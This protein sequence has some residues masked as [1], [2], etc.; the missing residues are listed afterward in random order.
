M[1][2]L[3]KLIYDLN[4]GSP[5]RFPDAI[6]WRLSPGRVALEQ[7][8]HIPQFRILADSA[9][10]KSKLVVTPYRTAEAAADESKRLFNLRLCGART[11]CTEN[12]YGKYLNNNILT[13]AQPFEGFSFKTYPNS[14]DSTHNCFFLTD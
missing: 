6:T 14:I 12:V 8:P 2:G 9:Y 5:G 7:Q 10:P 4:L 11:E 13:I 3:D 1:A